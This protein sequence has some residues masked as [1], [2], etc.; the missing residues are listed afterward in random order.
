MSQTKSS[1][2]SKKPRGNVIA[3]FHRRH[4]L[5]EC[6]HVSYALV[7]ERLYDV[8]GKN[9]GLHEYL[10]SIADPNHWPAIGDEPAQLIAQP[11]EQCVDLPAGDA[12]AFAGGLGGLHGELALGIGQALLLC[13][14]IH[15]PGC[16]LGHPAPN[17]EVADL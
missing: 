13:E 4:E 6:S 17:D 2:T 10:K 7:G 8:A 16:D 1:T 12:P 14:Q 11:V 3:C 5:I 15:L 9:A